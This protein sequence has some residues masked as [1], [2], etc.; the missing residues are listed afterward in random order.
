MS[1]EQVLFSRLGDVLWW[2][3]L[4]AAAVLATAIG[5]EM[6]HPQWAFN[7]TYLSLALILFL[8]E[9]QRPHLREWLHSDH[10]EWADL[11]HTALTKS[12]V[13]MLVVSLGVLGLTSSVGGPTGTGWWPNEWPMFAQ[14]GLGLL[15]AEFGLYWGHRL[16]HE[17]PWLWRFHA[18]HHSIKKLWFFNT[19]RFHFID[20]LKSLLLAGLL[21]A[22]AGAPNSVVIW[23]G[24]ITAYIGFLTHCNVRMHT[25]WIGY[26]FNTPRL[27]RWHHSMDLKEG[28]KNYGENLMLWD[29][30]FGTF[31]DETHRQPPREIGIRDAM[32]RRFIGQLLAPFRW[33]QFQQAHQ[34]GKLAP[35]ECL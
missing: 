9:R 13:Q 22:V 15:I 33:Q 10:Q 31:Y 29:V 1:G 2:P 19:G 16:A 11:G 17:W 30:L 24:A 20:T 8:L 25:G 27:H 23:I 35:G 14:V 7:L 28:N 26:V 4:F 6:G 5:M 18:V 34:Q 32:P 21:L 3:L 12:A